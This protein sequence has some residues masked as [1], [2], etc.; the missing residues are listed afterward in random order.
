M[1]RMVTTGFHVQPHGTAARCFYEQVFYRATPALA[2]AAKPAA[3]KHVRRKI[4]V[5]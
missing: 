5:I 1:E 3:D 2:V 4:F